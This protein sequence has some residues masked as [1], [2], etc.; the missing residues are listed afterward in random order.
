MQP[1]RAPETHQNATFSLY[2]DFVYEPNPRSDDCSNPFSDGFLKLSEKG[3]RGLQHSP[4]ERS[5]DLSGSEIR[6]NSRSKRCSNPFSDS[7][8]TAFSE[9]RR[10]CILGSSLAEACIAPVQLPCRSSCSLLVCQPF[11]IAAKKS[12]LYSA[13]YGTSGAL[14]LMF[15]RCLMPSFSISRSEAVLGVSAQ[16]IT[17][18]MPASSKA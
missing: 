17:R 15:P 5:R 3:R 1:R 9:V 8:L 14:G 18:S 16:A 7:F 12:S 2:H 4:T 6:P 13:K 10:L 11:A